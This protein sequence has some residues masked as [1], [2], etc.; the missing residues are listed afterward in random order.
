MVSSGK[1]SCHQRNNHKFFFHCPR[2]SQSEIQ[3]GGIKLNPL[4]RTDGKTNLLFVFFAEG[5]IY[6]F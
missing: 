3:E 4:V 5:C 2:I 1:W 6:L